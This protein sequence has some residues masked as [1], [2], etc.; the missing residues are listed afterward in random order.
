MLDRSC[1]EVKSTT[2]AT[3]DKAT[4]NHR[5]PA[6]KTVA[7]LP[8]FKDSLMADRKSFSKKSD[9]SPFSFKYV[10][11]VYIEVTNV[12]VVIRSYEWRVRRI[13]IYMQYS[14]YHFIARLKHQ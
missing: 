3:V 6:C 7:A 5:H 10:I 12:Y 14:V 11:V 8:S 13:E 2:V 9:N 1:F 4:V